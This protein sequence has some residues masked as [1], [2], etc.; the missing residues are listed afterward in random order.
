MGV[1]FIKSLGKKKIKILDIGSASGN[2]VK[3]AQANKWDITAVEPSMHAFKIL[4]KNYNCKIFNQ[5]FE[6]SKIN[7][8]FDIITCWASF[9][10]SYNTKKFIDKISRLLNKNG[11]VIFYISGNSNSLIMRVLRD[12]CVGFLFN[13]VNYFNPKSL[14]ICLKKKFKKKKLISDVN[15]IDQVNNFIN[16]YPTY[17]KNKF[18]NILKLFNQKT[19]INKIMGYKFFAVYEKKY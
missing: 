9:E 6:K 8:K 17:E 19:I 18:T 10:Y 2:F 14:H 4:K 5:T 12:K 11:Y 1:D 15:N 7:E 13:R 3:I 16:F